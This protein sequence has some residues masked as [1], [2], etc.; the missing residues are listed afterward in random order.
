[1]RKRIQVYTD[2]E[3][4]RRIDLAAAKYD[5]SVTDYCFTA[6]RERLAED[7]VMEHE[8]IEIAIKRSHDTNLIADLR[9]LREKIKVA[10]DGRPLDLDSIFDELHEERDRELLGV[11]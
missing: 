8:Q 7:D 6:I 4:K 5:A 1:M 2:P 11:R 9:A 10:R 3:T